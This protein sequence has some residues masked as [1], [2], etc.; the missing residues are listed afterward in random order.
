MTALFPNFFRE[1]VLSGGITFPITVK[2]VLFRNAPSLE[3]NMAQYAT[4]RNLAELTAFPAWEQVAGIDGYPLTDTTALS[5]RVEPNGTSYLMITEIEL[6]QLQEDIEVQAIGLVRTGTVAGV[7]EPLV[8]ATNTPTGGFMVVNGTDALTAAPDSV[9][10]PTGQ[11]RWLFG[12][13]KIPS[14]RPPEY[15]MIRPTE[16]PVAIVKG[17]PP[18]ETSN[19]QHIWCYPQRANMVAN[20]SFEKDTA[21]WGSNRAIAQ[22][23]GGAP[24]GGTWAGRFSGASPVI[25]ESNLFPT[26]IGEENSEQW[27]I[28]LMAKGDGLLKVG[29]VYWDPDYRMTA[30]DWGQDEAAGDQEWQLVPSGWVRVAC[31]RTAYQGYMAMVRL[32]T[33]GTTL[34]IDNVL[35]ERGYLKDW[36]YFDGDTT[37]GARDDFSW[38]GS[39]VDPGR[40]GA[41][42]SLWYNHRRAVVGR[43][44]A[45]T[46]DLTDPDD[47]ITDEQIEAMGLVYRWVPAGTTVVPHLDVLYPHDAQGPV[48]PKGATDI[49]PYAT[50]GDPAP[51]GVINPW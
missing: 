36:P 10:L 47:S 9:T 7:V 8:M 49:L 13:E 31:H 33:T 46:V 32:E 25:V 23:A 50:E 15:T 11:N 20:P 26:Q 48:R 2:V 51:T 37:Y 4:A 27:T 16:G 19:T 45:R 35:A 42:Y 22:V 28:Q 18:F 24:G 12:W 5:L 3:A 44:F 1:Q 14:P 38:Y 43:L 30:V 34:T 39:S 40:R 41:S 6:D 21:F 17:S 29:L